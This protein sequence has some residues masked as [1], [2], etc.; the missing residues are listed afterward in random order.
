[1]LSQFY[2]FFGAADSFAEGRGPSLE[3]GFAEEY[4]LRLEPEL[5]RA[6]KLSFPEVLLAISP[7]DEL[8][9]F[10]DVPIED[11][12]T[13]ALDA[14][15]GARTGRDDATGPKLEGTDGQDCDAEESDTEVPVPAGRGGRIPSKGLTPA[16][17]P[18]IL[19]RFFSNSNS[20][21]SI[22]RSSS[23][24]DESHFKGIGTAPCS[25]QAKIGIASKTDGTPL[26]E[27]ETEFFD[28]DH[29]SRLCTTVA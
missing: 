11:E 5:S 9:R 17:R 8:E 23:S 12:E 15:A 1:V 4:G 13:I 6:P 19:L 10:I 18:A 29:C 16:S 26:E 3:V 20:L 14:G 22:S 7:S 2:F 28:K 25:P 24:T 21:F 27:D